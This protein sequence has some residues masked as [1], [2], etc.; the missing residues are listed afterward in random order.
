[1]GNC[2]SCVPDLRLALP[3]DCELRGCGLDGLYRAVS[4][5][6]VR[7]KPVW[8]N[9]KQGWLWFSEVWMFANG[10]ENVGGMS[11]NIAGTSAGSPHLVKEWECAKKDGGW[12]AIAIRLSIE[13][14]HTTNHN[15]QCNQRAMREETLTQ[16][17][18][19]LL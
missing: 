18:D 15:E 2:S 5:K 7:G 9:D 14:G 16:M 12:Q 8:K 6:R 1:M 17:A 13:G 19:D 10:G 4:G 3:P 11:G